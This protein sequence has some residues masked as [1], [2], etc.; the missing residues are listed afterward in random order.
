MRNALALEPAAGP[1]DSFAA[2]DQLLEM[3]RPKRLVL[4]KYGC[5]QNGLAW[6]IGSWIVLAAATAALARPDLRALF[7]PSEGPLTFWQSMVDGAR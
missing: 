3:T 4:P 6:I 2:V 1:D 7:S 5:A